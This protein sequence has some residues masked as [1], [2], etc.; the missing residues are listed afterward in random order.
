MSSKTILVTGCS[1]GGIGAAIAIALASRAHYVFATARSISKIPSELAA[2]SNVT[3]LPLDVTSASSVAEAAQAVAASGR[4]LDVLLNNA[5]AG[6]S[7]PVLDINVD[8]A[9]ELYDVNVL[10]VI[11]TVQAFAPLLIKS[12]GR[13]VNL[14]SCGAAVNTPWIASYTS[15]KAALT[16]LSETL[17]LELS[18]FGVNVTTIMAGAVVSHFHDNEPQFRLPEGSYYAPIESIIAGWAS[19]KSKP[20]SGPAEQFVESII[21]DIVGNGRG[22][23][24]WKGAHAGSIRFLVEWLPS[25]VQDAAM[26]INQGLKELTQYLASRENEQ[27]N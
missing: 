10:G 14:S 12:K 13:V 1:A 26:S 22:G 3:I 21:D 8:K 16:T 9:M 5:G 25:W 15:T 18:P 27:H 19:G 7:M 24:V 17:R 11:R 23:L 4:G 20:Q 2:L 6:Y